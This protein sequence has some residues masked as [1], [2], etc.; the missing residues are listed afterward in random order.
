MCTRYVSGLFIDAIH[1][2][3]DRRDHVH[4]TNKRLFIIY[5]IHATC[6]MQTCGP[7]TGKMRTVCADVWPPRTH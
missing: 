1:I 7:S 6:K 2:C 3:D 4:I 5:S